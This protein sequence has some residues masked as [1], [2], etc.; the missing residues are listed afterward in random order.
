[1]SRGLGN[2]TPWLKLPR[3]TRDSMPKA[4]SEG[5]CVRVLSCSTHFVKSGMSR[6]K[7]FKSCGLVCF[8]DLDKRLLFHLWIKRRNGGTAIESN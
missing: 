3:T 6:L 2:R 1:M 4:G 7:T 5:S 8:V